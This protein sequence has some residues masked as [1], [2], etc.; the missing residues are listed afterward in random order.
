MKFLLNVGA[1]KAGTTWLYDYF[2]KHPDFIHYGKELNI[3]QR[4]DFVPR[5]ER[6][7]PGVDNIS[8]YFN[9]FNQRNHV[10][11]DFTHYE[12]STP[13]I[14]KILE[15]GLNHEIVPVYIMRDPIE[16]AWSAWNMFGGGSCDLPPAAN[17]VMQSILSCKYKETVEALDHVFGPERVLYFFYEDFFKQENVDLICDT[18]DLPRMAA[19]FT[20]I[21]K[22]AYTSP[23][24]QDFIRT[25]GTTIKNMDAV[26][27]INERFNNVPW[28]LSDYL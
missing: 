24:S 13:N 26:M 20:P 11:G 25:F 18:L 19:D 27:F 9:F 17:F 1:E 5:F 28:R 10:T 3:V 7:V 6:C 22:G 8:F 15:D 21:N 2:V 14:F 4:D 16:R 23:P 12:G